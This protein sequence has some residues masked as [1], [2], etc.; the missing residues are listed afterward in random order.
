LRGR[1]HHQLSHRPALSLHA[2]LS[3]PSPLSCFDDDDYYY[4][5]YFDSFDYFDYY[6]IVA[7]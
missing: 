6:S 4:F 3:E 5:D 1:T 7:G 2:S